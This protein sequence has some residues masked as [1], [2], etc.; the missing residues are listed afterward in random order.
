MVK[1]ESYD[2]TPSNPKRKSAAA[3]IKTMRTSFPIEK[4]ERASHGAWFLS[5]IVD[6]RAEFED[7]RIVI[8]NKKVRLKGAQEGKKPNPNPFGRN[9]K[10][11]K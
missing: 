4:L 2:F 3:Q 8:I 5:L 6:V 1:P 11:K 10:R 9:S 7:G